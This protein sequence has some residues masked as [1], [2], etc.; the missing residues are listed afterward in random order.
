MVKARP[1][2]QLRLRSARPGSNRIRNSEYLNSLQDI[3]AKARPELR[4]IHRLDFKPCFG[5]IAG[6]V[7]GCIFV[8][9]GKFGLA[10]KLPPGTLAELFREQDVIHL[11]YF[12]KGHV[13]KE[14]AVIPRPI[15]DDPGRFNRLLDESLEYA[16]TSSSQP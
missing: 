14:Y 9:R 2:A 6:Y 5:A 16:L 1:E 12:P 13:K 11:R 4:M 10:L 15:L 7:D 3:L 8:S